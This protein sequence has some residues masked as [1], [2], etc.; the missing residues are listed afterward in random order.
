[1][2]Q[3]AMNISSLFEQDSKLLNELLFLLSREQISL[4]NADIDAIENMLD[5]KGNLLQRINASVQVRYKALFKAGFEPNENGMAA[6]VQKN[7]VLKQLEA[8]QNFQRTLEQAKEFNR[9]NGQ[10][11]NKHFNRNQ[12]FLNQLQGKTSSDSV[13]GPNGQTTSQHYSRTA[14]TV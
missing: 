13:Y 6:W 10:L 7:A 9:L 2:P 4:V 14:L 8:W 11:I 12:Q 1:M 5:E 3:V